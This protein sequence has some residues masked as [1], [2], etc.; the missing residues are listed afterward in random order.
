MADVVAVDVVV[1]GRVQGVW[2][3]ASTR[4]VAERHG[5]TGWV[6]NEPGG[7]VRAHLEG[8]PSDVEAVLGWMRDGGPPRAQ[9]TAV[10]ASSGDV[11][12]VRG[13]RVR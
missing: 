13:F 11:E 6:R 10:E 3:R 12:G 8:F 4:E 9:V 2:F 1:Q 5:V 7:T